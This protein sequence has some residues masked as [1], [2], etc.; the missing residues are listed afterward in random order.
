MLKGLN[1]L[2]YLPQTYIIISSS[3]HILIEEINIINLANH[4]AIGL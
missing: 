4:G 3:N 2:N 1:Q